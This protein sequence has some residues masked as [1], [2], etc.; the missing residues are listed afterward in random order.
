M[1]ETPEGFEIVEARNMHDLKV[2]DMLGGIVV[3]KIDGGLTLRLD[4]GAAITS[5]WEQCIALAAANYR[6]LR[7]K[8]PPEPVV[9]ECEI[10]VPSASCDAIEAYRLYKMLRDHPGKRFNAVLTEIQ[11]EA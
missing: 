1:N 10:D 2:G 4:T 7:K 9:I 11:R 3:K 6:V 8:K 5:A